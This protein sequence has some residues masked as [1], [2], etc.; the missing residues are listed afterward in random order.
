MKIAFVHARRRL[1][2]L[3]AALEAR[4]GSDGWQ[5][6]GWGRQAVAVWFDQRRCSGVVAV[7]ST[8]CGGSA[9]NHSGTNWRAAG[10]AGGVTVIRE[11]SS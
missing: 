7:I 4:P 5:L 3:V 1:E 11:R 9:M 10:G 6:A 2:P 8:V